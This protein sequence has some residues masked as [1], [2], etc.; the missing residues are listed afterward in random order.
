MKRKIT[1][2][3][4]LILVGIMFMVFAVGSGSGASTDSS[5]YKLNDD[6]NVKTSSGEYKL[7]F[8]KIYETSERNQFSEKQ[9]NRVI[10]IEY[11]YENVSKENDLYVSDL[12]FKVYDKENNQLETYPVTTKSGGSVSKG[13]KA[14]GSVA[15]ALNSNSNYVELEYYDNMFNSKPD[16]KVVLEW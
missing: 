14:T 10:I 2:S 16:C 8:T 12:E 4:L 7:K 13:R 9:A 15:Y 6:I 5:T 3:L 11:E 1:S